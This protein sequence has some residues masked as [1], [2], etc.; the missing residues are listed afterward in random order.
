MIRKSLGQGKFESVSAP[1]KDIF[2]RL[3]I[4]WKCF[5]EDEEEILSQL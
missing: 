5:L 2:Q 3:D 1:F 4:G